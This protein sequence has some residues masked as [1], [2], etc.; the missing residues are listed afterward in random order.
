[1]LRIFFLIITLLC[2]AV[3]SSADSTL[4]GPVPVEKGSRVKSDSSA[5]A[6]VLDELKVYGFLDNPDP[7]Y[8]LD[9]DNTDSRPI[10]VSKDFIYD[11]TF[12]RNVN[13]ELFEWEN[14]IYY[15]KDVPFRP[16]AVKPVNDFPVRASQNT[17]GS[18]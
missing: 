8:I 9:M 2:G 16:E 10:R 5:R 4:A 13:K 3:C 6:I 14:E 11:P 17:K 12:M 7:I 18:Q 1:M 15:F